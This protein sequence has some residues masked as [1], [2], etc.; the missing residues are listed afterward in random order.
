ML[1]N[2]ILSQEKINERIDFAYKDLKIP[3]NAQRIFCDNKN[4]RKLYK[5]GDIEIYEYDHCCG[6]SV[7][8]GENFWK[9]NCWIECYFEGNWELTQNDI[10]NKFKSLFKEFSEES[11]KNPIVYRSDKKG[12]I[13]IYIIGRHFARNFADYIISITPFSYYTSKFQKNN[14]PLRE[15]L[16]YQKKFSA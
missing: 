9:H 1:F 8:N 13:D 12:I 14:I 10:W 11:R 4:F 16:T 15:I 5:C 7:Y 2:E 3:E 6:N